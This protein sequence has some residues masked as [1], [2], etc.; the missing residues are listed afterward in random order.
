MTDARSAFKIEKLNGKN[1]MA[2]KYEMKMLSVQC[3]L[4]KYINDKATE[5]I[6]KTDEYKKKNGE[7]LATIVLGCERSQHSIIRK[8]DS[9][10]D[11]WLALTTYYGK[12]T[13]LARI[14]LLKR[15]LKMRYD[16]S[17]DMNTFLSDYFDFLDECDESNMQ[18]A[19][20]FKA[21]LILA[22]LSDSYDG[23]VL[24]LGSLDD[25]QLTLSLM[26]QKL[27]D[28]FNKRQE[29]A[30]V[31]E[32]HLMYSKQTR[33]ASNNKPNERKKERV[34]WLFG[35]PDHFQNK[36]PKKTKQYA[37]NLAVT[38]S[39][40]LKSCDDVEDEVVTFMAYSGSV[41]EDGIWT[42][43]LLDT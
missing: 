36:C 41:D 18:F 28:E 31:K 42:R 5:D 34:C 25:N 10:R 9:A 40:G 37:A 15:L 2:W 27:L 13:T 16:D 43:G 12:Q 24:S 17:M 30:D 38:G 35:S 7:A 8:Y 29:R 33:K 22:S 21:S 26:R 39:R 3:G 20:F 23:A 6:A 32:E 19:E 4:W 1:F 14:N 11:A